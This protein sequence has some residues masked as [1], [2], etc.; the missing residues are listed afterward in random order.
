[1][2]SRYF[3]A[4]ELLSSAQIRSAR[5]LELAKTIVLLWAR[6]DRE[7]SG[8]SPAKSI[9]LTFVQDRAG[10]AHQVRSCPRQG[11]RF[12]GRSHDHEGHQ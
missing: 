4:G 5:R 7:V 8:I 1:M 6:S 11:P 3:F 2:C 12:Q 10:R 9:E